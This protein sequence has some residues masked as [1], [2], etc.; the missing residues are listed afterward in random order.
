MS[1]YP[2]LIELYEAVIKDCYNYYLKKHTEEAKNYMKLHEIIQNKDE[3][4]K[5]HL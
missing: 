5:Q 1:K 3:I 2:K 4:I